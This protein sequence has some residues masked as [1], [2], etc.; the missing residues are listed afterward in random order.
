MSRSVS[1][2]L[3]KAKFKFP[4]RERR[5]MGEDDKSDLTK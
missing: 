1:L 5:L 4:E 2:Y 3:G